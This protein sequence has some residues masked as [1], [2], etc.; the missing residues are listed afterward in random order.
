[1]GKFSGSA[2]AVRVIPSNMGGVAELPPPDKAAAL[3]CVLVHA[4]GEPIPDRLM[5]ALRAKKVEVDATDDIYGALVALC[6]YARDPGV[7]LPILA[8]VEPARIPH[9]PELVEAA[10]VYAPKAVHWVY[11]SS[12]REQIREV[13]E[14]DLAAWRADLSTTGT[15]SLIEPRVLEQG[16]AEIR[17]DSGEEPRPEQ[18]RIA[19]NGA[20]PLADAPSEGQ[21]REHPG[22]ILTDEEMDM[23][24]ADEDPADE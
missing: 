1:M 9:A 21:N 24:L 4:S 18:A 2:Y 10:S 8:L 3:R 17:T 12:P 15:G 5:Q 13:R 22:S 11:A 7:A 6:G 19:P 14:S 16:S 23:L 20:D